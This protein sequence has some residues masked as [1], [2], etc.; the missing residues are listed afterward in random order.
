[1]YL[2]LEERGFN[3]SFL[4]FKFREGRNI[5]K[6][7]RINDQI[8]TKKVRVIAEDGEQLGIIDI[9]DAL[10]ASE[11]RSLDLVEIAPNAT[12][13]VCRIMNY[14]KYKYEQSKREKES[15]KNQKV[16]DVKE[17]RITPT[18][19]VHDL[20]VKTNRAKEFLSH[21]NKVKFSVRF[22][23]REIVHSHL[24]QQVLTEIAQKLVE[25]ADL[26]RAPRLE[27]HSMVMILAPKQ[28]K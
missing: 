6:D 12:P 25:F 4:I 27:G 7:L 14:G 9:R 10:K 19:D 17:L 22:R 13:P 28:E 15:R 3:R 26:E 5:S 2:T 16:I 1:M 20:E 24:G 18:T 21:G 8:R 23:G 11:E